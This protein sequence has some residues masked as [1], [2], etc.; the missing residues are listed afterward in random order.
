MLRDY[1]QNPFN[2][3]Y[4]NRLV[5]R[6]FPNRCARLELFPVL[7]DVAATCSYP[8]RGRHP[9]RIVGVF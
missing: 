4:E 2:G 6:I 5:S 9:F 3:G 8:A 1:G 7:R